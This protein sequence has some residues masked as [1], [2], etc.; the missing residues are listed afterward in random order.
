MRNSLK[1]E[2]PI[3]Q[4]HTRVMDLSMLSLMVDKSKGE[5]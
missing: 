1:G 2:K 5:A 4:H 3:R